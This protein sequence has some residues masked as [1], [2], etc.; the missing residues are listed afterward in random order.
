MSELR[1]AC[2]LGP[3]IVLTEEN[4]IRHAVRLGAVLAVSE[5]DETGTTCIIQITGNRTVEVH[6]SLEAVLR[7]FQ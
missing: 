3:F 7:W 4:G 6:G 1:P 5:A 2:R